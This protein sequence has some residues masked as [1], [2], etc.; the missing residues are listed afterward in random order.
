MET[1]H[2]IKPVRKR[3]GQG[4]PLLR[5]IAGV[6]VLLG[7]LLLAAGGPLTAPPLQSIAAA[8]LT[9]RNLALAAILVVLLV[10][11]PRRTLGLVVLITAAMHGVDAVFDALLHNIP[12]AAGSAVFAGVFL[13]VGAWL[14]RGGDGR[15][16]GAG[17]EVEAGR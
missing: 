9:D 13:V 6:V 3:R 7:A 15:L 8:Y 4:P 14:V 1:A 16:L 11:A 17:R 12:A 5:W 2:D 10:W